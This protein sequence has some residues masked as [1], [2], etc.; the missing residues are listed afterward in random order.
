MAGDVVN[1]TF[2]LASTFVVYWQFCAPKSATAPSAKTLG[3]SK[4]DH[5]MT[6]Q[7]NFKT[8]ADQPLANAYFGTFA[9]LQTRQANAN[10]NAKE[11]KFSSRTANANHLSTVS[12]HTYKFVTTWFHK[13]KQKEKSGG[14]ATANIFFRQT[15]FNK[16]NQ[17]VNTQK[18]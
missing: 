14:F 2:Y 16:N 17:T 6:R 1:W 11:P 10:K 15:H 3:A 18:I 9:F 12:V 5:N 7:T 4:D 8:T 13:R